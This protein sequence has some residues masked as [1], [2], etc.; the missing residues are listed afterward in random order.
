M[1]EMDK[2]FACPVLLTSGNHDPRNT[3]GQEAWDS[4]IP[5]YLASI[6]RNYSG[7]RGN[8]AVNI[9][10]DLFVFYDLNNP[11]L[12][13]LEKVFKDNPKSRPDAR[14]RQKDPPCP[15]E[16]PCAPYGQG[17]QKGAI[18]PHCTA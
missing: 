18:P 2:R 17:W 16:I 14:N 13:Y 11:D 12:D 1:S 9:G 15:H 5:P 10:K 8:Y 7:K 6:V 3:Y 4:V